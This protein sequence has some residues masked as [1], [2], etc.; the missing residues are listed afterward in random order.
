MHVFDEGYTP[1]PL[2]SLIHVAC[3]DMSQKPGEKAFLGRVFQTLLL[4]LIKNLTYGNAYHIH[5]GFDQ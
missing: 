1:V 3:S 5:K 4:Y 2:G